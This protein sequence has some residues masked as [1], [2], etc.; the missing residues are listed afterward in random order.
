MSLVA[1]S[2]APQ[3]AVLAASLNVGDIFTAAYGGHYRVTGWYKDEV[4]GCPKAVSAT[5]NETMFAGCATVERGHHP[6]GWLKALFVMPWA[7]RT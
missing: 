1:D 4:G 6:H 7:V 5:G 3:G 2:R